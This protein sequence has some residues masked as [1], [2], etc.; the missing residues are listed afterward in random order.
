MSLTNIV[1]WSGA[2]AGTAALLYGLGLI[3]WV[4]KLPTGSG[5]MVEISEAIQQG[6]TAFMKRQYS[7]VAV[8]ALVLFLIIGFGI[9]DNWLTAAGFA[10][11]AILSS[12]AG[13][14]GMYVATRANVR[15]AEAA[16]SGLPA[17]LKVA[18]QG[19]AVTGILVAA[20]A[21]LAV[22]WMAERS[23]A[24][25]QTQRPDDRAAVG[26]PRAKPPSRRDRP[27]RGCGRPG[28]GAC[29]CTGRPA[30]G[31]LPARRRSARR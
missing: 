20:L 17:A 3:A 5:K 1:L 9:K 23:E 12:I 15:T 22:A 18:F 30:R 28:K 7:A 29:P 2:A 31:S 16:K 10:T 11:G 21:L 4:M 8:V 24:A 14:I 26:G 13:F 19:G 6:A 27:C 25:G